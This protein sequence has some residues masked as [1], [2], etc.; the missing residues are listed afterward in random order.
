MLNARQYLLR[1]APLPRHF[2]VVQI[3]SLRCAAESLIRQTLTL[4]LT[5]V[6]LHTWQVPG[7]VISQMP[8][9]LDGVVLRLPFVIGVDQITFELQLQILVS[10]LVFIGLLENG[11]EPY[12]IL[13]IILELVDIFILALS[14]ALRHCCLLQSIWNRPPLLL[15]RN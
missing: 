5:A 1:V 3:I 7:A 9:E 13:H 15:M 11:W 14:W 10:S 12:V 2:R 4:R 6:V 8:H